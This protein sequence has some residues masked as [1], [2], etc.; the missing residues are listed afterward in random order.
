[1]KSQFFT[2][3]YALIVANGDSPERGL[4]KQI[5]DKSDFIVAADG[6]GNALAK[7]G[8]TP[9]LIL[10]DMDSLRPDVLSGFEAKNVDIRPVESQQE[11]DL[12]KGIRYLIDQGYRTI[13]LTAVYG[14]RMDHTFATLELLKKFKSSVNIYIITDTFEIFLIQPGRHKI[15]TEK[16]AIFSIFGFSRGYD[17]ETENLKYPLKGENLF[18]GSRGVSNRSLSDSVF[19]SFTRGNLLIFRSL[20]SDGTN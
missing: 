14:D 1:L 10:G 13:V 16:N 19:I 18:E 7:Q 2:K 6:G 4:L 5:A 9:D 8:L 15:Q 20:R 3:K 17:I 12:E 11:N